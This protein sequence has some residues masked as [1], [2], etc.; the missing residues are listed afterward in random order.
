MTDIMG[1]HL[2]NRNNNYSKK[3][4]KFSLDV[5]QLLVGHSCLMEQIVCN[6]TM[7]QTFYS[8]MILCHI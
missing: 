3:K 6:V 7:E 5:H 4:F 8:I 2:R 1:N